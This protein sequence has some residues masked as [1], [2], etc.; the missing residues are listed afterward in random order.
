M[1]K[2]NYVRKFTIFLEKKDYI[3]FFK[4]SNSIFVFLDKLNS[5]K[6]I[7]L[8]N[9]VK[10][11]KLF[12]YDEYCSYWG[13]GFIGSY[14]IEKLIKNIKNNIIIIDN[15]KNGHKKLIN[16]KAIFIKGDIN[17]KKLLIK[18]LKKY[19]VQTIIH[20]AALLN[21]NDAEKNKLK[22]YNNNIKSTRNLFLACK[23]SN[24]T[25]FIFS[26]SC[27]IYGNIEEDVSERKKTDPKGYYA[28]TKFKG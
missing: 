11:N 17:D 3:F 13:A 24:V 15:L 7:V 2:D 20:L 18:I 21:I 27:S 22:Y 28:Y 23:N 9:Y 5:I 16:K 25:N 26:S 12:Q 1:S 19:N 14:I 10:I 8:S 6:L 4:Y